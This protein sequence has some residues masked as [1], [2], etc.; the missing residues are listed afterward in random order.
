MSYGTSLADAY[1]L[2]G[3]YTNRVLKGLRAGHLRV[4]QWSKIELMINLK[5][6]KTRGLA[7]YEARDKGSSLMKTLKFTEGAF[8]GSS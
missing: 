7:S 3:T 6:A 5:T 8:D 2:A 1:H 4:Q